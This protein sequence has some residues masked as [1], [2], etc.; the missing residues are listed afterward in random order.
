MN[1]GGSWR[2]RHNAVRNQKK[3][4][5]MKHALRFVLCAV[6]LLNSA[7]SASAALQL[8]ISD[9]TPGGTITVVD[10]DINDFS[11][12]VGAVSYSGPIGTNWIATLSSGT[13]KPI[14]GSAETPRIDLNTFNLS[15]TSGGNLTIELTDTDFLEDGPTTFALG[16]NSAGSLS[17]NT[18]YDDGNGHFVKTTAISSSGPFSGNFSFGGTGDIVAT[19]PYS[20]TVQFVISHVAG[21]ITA[22]DSE[23]ILNPPPF[24]PPDIIVDCDE[25][26]DPYVNLTLGVPVVFTTPDCA[27]VTTT[28]VDSQIGNVVTRTWTS[29]DLCNNTNICI[30]IL[31]L[32]T[33]CT[34]P[35][36]NCVQRAVGGGPCSD[37]EANHAVWLPGIA[38]DFYFSPS[39]SF[40]ENPDGTAH[41]A[42]T[43]VSASDP[44]KTFDI[45][46]NLS[47]RTSVPPPGSP[48]KDL[49]D[50]AY[51]EDGGPVNTDDWYYYTN[52]TGTF[53]G[54]GSLAG[55]VLTIVPTGPAFQV[56]LG[57]SGK[58]LHYGASAWFIWT[59][60]S[61][62]DNGPA[63]PVTGQGDFNLDI[64]ECIEIPITNCVQRAVGG[65]KCSDATTSHAVW[66]P[67]I[68]TDFVFFPDAGTFVENP[69]GTA[70][71]SGTIARVSNTNQGFIVDVVLTGR[72]T[73][74]P[75]GSPKKDLKDCAYEEDDGPIDTDDWYYYAD[76]TGTLTG[77]GEFDGAIIT[78]VPT[79]PA[80][81]IGL[82]ANNKNL[83]FG[84]SAWFIWTVTQQP[85][86]G[87]PL[88]VTG[89]G[90]FNL[91]IGDCPPANLPGT[92]SICGKVKQD[93]D[94]NGS[95]SGEAGLPGWTVTLKSGASIIDSVVTDAAGDYC[96]N[97]LPPGTYLIVVTPEPGFKQTYD[98]DGSKDHKHSVKISEGENKTG[99]YFG[100]TGTQP[101]V[102]LYV[103]GPDTAN[104]GD[105]ITYT[106][107]VTNTGN[108][109]LYGGIK[110]RSELL[111][112]QIFHQTPVAP[113]EGFVF[114]RTYKVK[115][116]DS[117]PL[118]NT[119]TV[120]GDPPGSLDNVVKA[121]SVNTVI[122]GYC[123]PAAPT[124]LTDK[125]GNGFVKL[126]WKAVSGASSYKVKRSTTKGGPYILITSGLT[127]TSYTDT[128]VVNGVVYYYVV[129][130]SR[131][132]VPSEDS[133]EVSSIPSAG[134][135]SPLKNKD[136]GAV[137]EAGGAS[138]SGGTF[139]VI[140]SGK[141]IYGSSDEF[142]YVY[143]QANGNCTIVARVV[144]LDDT[145][146]FAKAGVM[147]RNSLSSN[148]KH[149][150][151]FIT[152][153]NGVQFM[154][155]T[156]TGGTAGHV[157]VPGP[158]PPQWLKVV[159]NGNSFQ[160]YYSADGVSWNLI[161]SETF[162][163]NSTVYI[164]LAVTS[165]DDG[166]LNT[167][168]FDNVT[169]TP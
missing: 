21:G 149:A 117:T 141:Y 131:H 76:F 37:S 94:A 33:N 72:T 165:H 34:P 92:G 105:T 39:G 44:S 80:F 169:I 118:V 69:D 84:A 64:I 100:Y 157:I 42:G 23:F 151:T 130:S 78:L 104:C 68:G 59:V 60:T 163:M 167:A 6:A 85:T 96:F 35:T 67:G 27:P 58:N 47:G 32:S 101:D 102:A 54:G 155:R 134:L 125:P 5:T 70:Q 49:K 116:S 143:Q 45:E 112:G 75:P 29:Y 65:G 153:T 46:V 51:S 90:D 154:A 9:G 1:V 108:T 113:G 71:L 89:Q 87:P 91:D 150:S 20:I 57:A 142:H 140:G 88:Q 3:N 15:S 107:A 17:Y 147:I 55:A 14:L 24:C 36:T 132:A 99:K 137:A 28:Y 111:G 97:N 82:G 160:G 79:G 66:M 139:N 121:V 63:L 13:S 146:G 127:T 152:A 98:P 12:I 43:I 103:T 18:F 166:T 95:V 162:S 74:P 129:V 19:A 119:V 26:L 73:V 83:K 145:D 133:A 135:P 168:V 128:N 2:T 124:G 56:G 77:I 120:I 52:F 22:C 40:V 93:C 148:S 158:T 114:T 10:Q 138:H 164:G 109:C 62:P 136:I 110:V 61:Q 122:L 144:G 16:G 41:I 126:Y 4:K 7:L 115:S 159:R 31:T 161:S 81:Q 86:S 38:T 25:S 156:S 106:F 123:P 53:T 11:P 50:C 8:R 48:K 30:Q